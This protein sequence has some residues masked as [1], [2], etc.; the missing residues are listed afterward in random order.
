MK[1]KHEG[2]LRLKAEKIE[3]LD[4]EKRVIT[5]KQ[6]A[7]LAQAEERSRE[8]LERIQELE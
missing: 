8:L 1:Q 2:T 3:I 4:N 5:E 6:K 7:E